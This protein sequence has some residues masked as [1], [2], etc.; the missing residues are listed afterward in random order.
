[1]FI[2]LFNLFINCFVIFI[3][4]IL[5]YNSRLIFVSFAI[6]YKFHCKKMN[7]VNLSIWK[8]TFKIHLNIYLRTALLHKMY[9][10]DCITKNEYALAQIM[11]TIK[12]NIM[13]VFIICNVISNFLVTK[14]CSKN[15]RGHHFN[16]QF[17]CINSNLIYS[18]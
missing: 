2:E 4:S 10:I 3:S 9:E 1:M 17:K 13:N 12:F 5:L 6:V 7:I 18:Y 15:L 16:L 11:F 8:F 14:I